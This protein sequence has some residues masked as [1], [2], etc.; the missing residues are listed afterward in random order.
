MTQRLDMAG[1]AGIITSAPTV[2]WGTYTIFGTE[3]KRAVGLSMGCEDYNL[4]YR[5]AER[6]QGPMI[7][8][9]TD[10]KALGEVPA[11]NTIATIRGSE[12]PNEY[13]MLSAHFDSWEGG[14]GATDNGTG[15]VVMMEAIRILRQVLPNPKRTIIV[16]HW[17]GEEQGLNG[18]RAFAADRPEVVKGLAA[19]FNQ[20]NG[21]GR[22]QSTSAAGLTNGAVVLQG[23]LNRM[24]KEFRD[25]VRFTGVGSPASGGTDHAAFDCYGAP[26]F[27]LSSLSWDYGP[28]THHT[29][30]DTFDKVV[31]DEVKGNATITAMLVYMASEDPVFIARDRRNLNEPDPTAGRG[32]RGGGRGGRGGETVIGQ[33]VRT[34]DSTTVV[35]TMP[36]P[37]PD[38]AGGRGRGAGGGGGG[39]GGRAANP[40]ATPTTDALGWPLTCSKGTRTSGIAQ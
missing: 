33:V 8:V 28:Y 26:G 36:N 30:R 19:L 11:Y 35:F 12:K 40:N 32:G 25:Q 14:S 7:R 20:D 2:G 6:N 27:G 4:L 16:G 23:W 34:G 24:P 10:G 37:R 13:V 29:N 38:T 39:G 21:T 17:N 1:A 22:I 18:S 9:N 31:I 15:T 5:L 3:N